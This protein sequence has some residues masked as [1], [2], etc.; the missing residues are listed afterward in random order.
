M[1]ILSLTSAIYLHSAFAAFCSKFQAK[2]EETYSC[3]KLI[4]HF[5]NFPTADLLSTATMP[6]KDFDTTKASINYQLIIISAWLN[7]ILWFAC[8]I[9]MIL[10][11]IF[12]IDFKL[13]RV[14][15]AT[16]PEKTDETSPSMMPSKFSQEKLDMSDDSEYEEAISKKDADETSFTTAR[17]SFMI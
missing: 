3:S 8:C 6:N 5:G 4:E 10:R 16:L 13:V 9:T 2:L 12:M 7:A 17:T 1:S 15:V 14:T 11:C